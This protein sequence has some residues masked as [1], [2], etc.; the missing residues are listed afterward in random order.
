MMARLL[1]V[2]LSCLLTSCIAVRGD[3]IKIDSKWPLEGVI[4]T[5]SV[6][7]SVTGNF[8]SGTSTEP[9]N[10]R[11]MQLI[12][13]QAQKAY[14]DSAL[15]SQVSLAKEQSDLKAEVRVTEEGSKALAGIS[16]FISGFS[17]GLIPGYVHATL[18][19]ETVFKNQAGSEIG[20][21]KKSESVSLWIQLFLVLA[22]PFK[23]NPNHVIRDIYYDLNRATLD[24][25]LKDGFL[26]R[27]YAAS[28]N[29]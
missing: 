24:Q 19:M 22:M 17:M 13:G 1:L 14:M 26:F 9:T 27:P 6:S 15:F 3:D 10:P 20:S 21:I 4:A 8:S 16:G 12:E 28:A 7:L 18:T 11:A 2:V 23:D 5:K 29:R 25:A